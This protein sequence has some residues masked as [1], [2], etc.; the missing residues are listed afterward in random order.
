MRMGKEDQ[1]V[2]KSMNTREEHATLEEIIPESPEMTLKELARYIKGRNT[3]PTTLMEKNNVDTSTKKNVNNKK[4]SIVKERLSR[5]RE[6][7]TTSHVIDPGQ[8]QNAFNKLI[9]GTNLET[10][11]KKLEI[12]E[13]SP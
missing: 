6:E 8:V 4:T 2:D 5:Q 7:A 1:E 9:C 12:D 13:E 11:Q 3:T 10:S